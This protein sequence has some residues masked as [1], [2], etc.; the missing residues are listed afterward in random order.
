M[1]LAVNN[2]N[3]LPRDTA[4]E[5]LR[6]CC[7]SSRWIDEMIVRRPYYSVDE[8][9]VA[10]DEVWASTTASDWHDAFAHHPRIGE[11]AVATQTA[12]SAAW[13]ASEQSAV[14]TA[15]VATQADIAAINRE[16]ERRFGYIYIVCAA[17]KSAEQL[18]TIA[19]ARLQNDAATELNVAA[20]EQRQITQLRLRT[21][22]GEGK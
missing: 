15:P 10:A 5:L 12:Q 18:L 14:A 13:S 20:E 1:T 19:K 11:R 6:S 17:D 3:E 9:L 22:F 16:Y 4:A 21:M 8:L 2:L 7:G